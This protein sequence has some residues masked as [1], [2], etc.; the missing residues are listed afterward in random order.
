MLGV[1]FRN[2]TERIHIWKIGYAVRMDIFPVLFGS[3]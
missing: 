1:G 2:R 3:F